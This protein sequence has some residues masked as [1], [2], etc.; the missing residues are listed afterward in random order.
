V[1]RSSQCL[2]ES[3]FAMVPCFDVMISISFDSALA[4]KLGPEAAIASGSCCCNHSAACLSCFLLGS[5]VPNRCLSR[6]GQTWPKEHLLVGWH[7]SPEAGSWPC[8]PKK[9]MAG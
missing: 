4:A 3:S 1:T 7:C 5:V 6:I 9:V 8:L 2:V